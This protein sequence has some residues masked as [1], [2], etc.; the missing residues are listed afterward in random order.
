VIYR[1]IASKI[2]FAI[3]VCAFVV[4]LIWNTS[5]NTVPAVAG[6]GILAPV[7]IAHGPT[8]PPDPWAGTENLVAHGPTLPPDPWAGTENIV[9][10]PTLPP[11]PWAGT[12][13]V[14]A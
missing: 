5:Q 6:H 12:E 9:H 8:L 1:I 7:V 2:A 13:N 14:V 4:A 11:D 3:T 10:G